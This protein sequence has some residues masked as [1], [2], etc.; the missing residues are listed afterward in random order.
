MNVTFEGER[1][2]QD[3]DYTAEFIK[4]TE[5]GTATV[6]INGLGDYKAFIKNKTAT[7]KIVPQNVKNLK[8][9][10]RTTS[11]IT[12]KWDKDAKAEG[13]NVQVYRSGKWVSAGNT[14][15]TSFKVT[16]LSN[17]SN[18]SIRVR[19]YKTGLLRQYGGRRNTACKG[20]LAQSKHKHEYV[21]NAY[22]E[23]AERRKLL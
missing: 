22:M 13:Y 7:F 18:Y 14:A 8:Y 5:I 23:K 4:N 15:A 17:A 9:S 2:E 21:R 20:N 11:S 16:G 3:R 10:A 12:V 19:A 6:K 1:L